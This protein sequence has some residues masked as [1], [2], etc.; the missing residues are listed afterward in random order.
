MGRSLPHPAAIG[1]G[2]PSREAHRSTLP[3]KP[4]ARCWLCG[5]Q[6]FAEQLTQATNPEA[7]PEQPGAEAPRLRASNCAKKT[8]SNASVSPPRRGQSPQTIREPS[9]YVLRLE[10]ASSGSNGVP[11]RRT[12]TASASRTGGEQ[13][14]PLRSTERMMG[15]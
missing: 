7:D 6:R 8:I 4:I 2:K 9:P 13:S 14:V 5:N 10:T 3:A 12:P 11:I 15:S 1:P